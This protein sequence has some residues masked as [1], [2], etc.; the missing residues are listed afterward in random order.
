MLNTVFN[1][2]LKRVYRQ[3]ATK[4][5]EHVSHERTNNIEQPLCPLYDCMRL[6]VTDMAVPDHAVS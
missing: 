5:V 4:P 2:R 6:T 3:N 1:K